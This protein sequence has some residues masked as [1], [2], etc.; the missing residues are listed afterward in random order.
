M[1]E[2]GNERCQKKD[3]IRNYIIP[4][5]GDTKLSEI[6]TRFMEKY[7][8]TLLKTPSVINPIF[9]KRLN[10]TVGTSTI[11]DI[12]KLL[13]SAFDQ[14]VKWELME[15]NPCIHATVPKHKAKKREIWTAEQLMYA[16]EVCDD[17]F[18]KLALNLAFAGSLRIGELLGLTWDCVDIFPEAIQEGRSYIY[19]NKELQRVSKEAVKESDGKDVLLI[20]PEES[21]RCKTVRILKTP[22]TDSSVRKI[23]LPKSVA[24]MLIDWKNSQK[25]IK[26][27][28]GEEYQDYRQVKFP[29]IG[30]SQ[31]TKNRKFTAR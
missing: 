3:V 6:N 13:R 7:Y 12:H 8:Q 11:R 1:K 20:F 27:V 15:K 31:R 25:E 2:R 5:I 18:T 4:I 26:E 29:F 30:K 23:F 9:G 14:A 16:I 22:K 10:E 19:V 28:L 24:M 17:E 21:K